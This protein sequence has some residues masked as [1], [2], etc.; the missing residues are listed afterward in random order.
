[1]ETVAALALSHSAFVNPFS[2]WTYS[3]NSIVVASDGSDSRW[4]TSHSAAAESTL[5]TVNYR[6]AT[7]IDSQP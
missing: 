1:M 4:Q 3:E 2:V 7:I 6:K 5:V